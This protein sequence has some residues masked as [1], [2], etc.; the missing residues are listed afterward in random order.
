MRAPEGTCHTVGQL[1]YSA[2]QHMQAATAVACLS[3]HKQHS[4]QCT[5]QRLAQAVTWTTTGHAAHCHALLCHAALHHARCAVLCP[6]GCLVQAIHI[7]AWH[8]EAAGKG[9]HTCADVSQLGVACT[10]QQPTQHCMP[11]NKMMY[12]AAGDGFRCRSQHC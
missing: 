1:Q 7:K 3:T 5:S 11:T 2:R 10:A 4:P 9:L 6:G 8:G 12:S